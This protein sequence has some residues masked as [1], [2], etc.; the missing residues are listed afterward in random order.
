M[1]AS[2]KRH[3]KQ[4]SD[5]SPDPLQAAQQECAHLLAE[6][7]RLREELDDL[8][9][10]VNQGSL[11]TPEMPIVVKK[12]LN[13]AG[14]W[15]VHPNDVLILTPK[16]AQEFERETSISPIHKNGISVCFPA[17]ERERVVDMVAR[18]MPELLPKYR[19]NV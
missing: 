2:C 7:R 4:L 5:D 9:M 13:L 12:A 8:R 16:L 3:R 10:R 15:N 11:Q 1:T 19:R 18:L 14:Y 17:D 6:N